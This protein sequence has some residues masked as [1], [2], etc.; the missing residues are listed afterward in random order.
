[1]I[2][3]VNSPNASSASN[4][5]HLAF[6]ALLPKLQTH[7]KIYFRHIRCPDAKAEKIAETVALAW[8]WFLRLHERGKDIGAFAT[9]FVYLVAR[10]AKSGRRLCGVERARDVMSPLAQARHG[11]RVELLPSSTHE[12]IHCL[13]R[14]Q[15]EADAY[16]E[17]LRDN[18]A[19]P[20]PDA[21]AF[22]I[23][24]PQF[25]QGLPERDREMAMFLS[26]GHRAQ[27]AAARFDLSPGRVTQLR[28]AWCREWRAGQGEGDHNG[29]ITGARRVSKR[30]H[31]L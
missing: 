17:R 1:M 30:M 3:V 15:D 9:V 27:T 13:V 28:Q 2:A 19:T 4:T 25:L 23:D 6:L 14:G 22:R 31:N 26:L 5:L 8:K 29:R 24:F 18:T 11:F 10:A 12:S 7:A 21:A 16:A 20:P